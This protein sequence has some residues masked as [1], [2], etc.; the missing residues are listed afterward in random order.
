MG[1]IRAL[2]DH[3][4]QELAGIEGFQDRHRLAGFAASYGVDRLPFLSVG[5]AGA[6]GSFAGRAV[7][8]PLQ[9]GFGSEQVAAVDF[10]VLDLALGSD[11]QTGPFMDTA[12][13]IAEP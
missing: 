6:L 1:P 8:Q 10:P 3:W 2:A 11:D 9:K 13:V 4:R 5:S 12:A 7:G